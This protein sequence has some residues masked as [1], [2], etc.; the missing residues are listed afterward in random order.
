MPYSITW[1]NAVQHSVRVVDG[2][3]L[4]CS[5]IVSDAILRRGGIRRC[6]IAAGWP[7]C[8]P[9][10][11]WEMVIDLLMKSGL[12]SQ[13]QRGYDIGRDTCLSVQMTASLSCNE[14]RNKLTASLSIYVTHTRI[15]VL[16][17]P[18]YIYEKHKLHETHL[19]KTLAVDQ[20]NKTSL[21]LFHG[22]LAM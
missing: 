11:V 21:R 13:P 9:D 3:S 10:V 17:M 14:T 1:L 19:T 12:G 6:V 22:E 18:E 20:C 8:P 7:M 4:D 15:H 16:Y 2:A 5:Y